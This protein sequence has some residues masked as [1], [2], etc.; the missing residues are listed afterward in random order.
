MKRILYSLAALVMF[1][2]L[3]GT[4]NAQSFYRPTYPN[5]GY[6]IPNF[7]G[8]GYRPITPGHYDFIP[9]HYDRHRGHVD[10]V[11]PHYDYDRG[12]RHN[13]TPTPYYPR[14]GYYTPR[15]PYC[16]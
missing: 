6:G 12:N 1:L 15:R 14:G 3:A 9:G 11:P 7:P 4:A 8:S 10:Y 2:G 16:D 5:G 13:Y